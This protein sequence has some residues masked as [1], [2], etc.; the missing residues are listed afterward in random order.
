MS[1][2]HRFSAGSHYGARKKKEQ[3]PGESP[4]AQNKSD[5]GEKGEVASGIITSRILK[6]E[7]PEFR[8]VTRIALNEDPGYRM[9]AAIIDSIRYDLKNGDNPIKA[10]SYAV[11]EN[12]TSRKISLEIEISTRKGVR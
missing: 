8:E 10:L 2:K 4:K 9:R 11:L 1:C 12:H 5:A 7:G 6:T 3:A